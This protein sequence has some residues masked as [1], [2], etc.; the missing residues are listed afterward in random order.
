MPKCVQRMHSNATMQVML[1]TGWDSGASTC[2]GR[3]LGVGPAIGFQS[4]CGLGGTTTT[5]RSTVIVRLTYLNTCLRRT[6]SISRIG[7]E[8]KI[9]SRNV[10]RFQSEYQHGTGRNIFCAHFHTIA[11]RIWHVHNTHHKGTALVFDFS[12]LLVSDQ[13]C[14]TTQHYFVRLVDILRHGINQE[15][16]QEM[17]V[18]TSLFGDLLMVRY[19]R[20]L[21]INK[22]MG[23]VVYT[24][25][26]MNNRATQ[27]ANSNILRRL[28][29]TIRHHPPTSTC[30]PSA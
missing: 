2:S 24:W 22:E 25:E 17:W 29:A 30:F 4:F 3:L 5:N 1:Q 12:F 13:Q 10:V 6:Y 8:T 27:N 23:M 7:K 9:G 14:L 16:G 18:W 20:Y 15:R 28:R 11:A 19:N 21:N 26:G